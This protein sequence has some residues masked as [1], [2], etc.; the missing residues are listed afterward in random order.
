[1][2]ID[3]ALVSCD[4]TDMRIRGRNVLALLCGTTVAGF[5]WLA[6]CAREGA[7]GARSVPPPAQT[8]PSTIASLPVPAAATTPAATVEPKPTPPEPEPVLGADHR[9]AAPCEAD[10]DCGWDDPCVPARCLAAV[11][12]DV[13]MKCAE[14]RPPPGAC[15]CMSG[16]CT[17]KPKPPPKASGP[18]ENRGCV[19]DRAGGQCIADT[20]GVKVNFRTNSGVDVGPSC[21]CLS[22][23]KGCDFTWYEP[24]PC[25]TVRDCWV[26]SLPRPHPVKRPGHLRGR[27]FKPC[28]DGEV[29]PQCSQAGHCVLGSHWSC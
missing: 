18:C 10:A 26:E 28:S 24:V 22:P 25:K 14:S 11:T 29:S 2:V 3:G 20:R 13:D 19:V 17:L 1:M 27:D 4:L 23:A 16:R 6:G 7:S 21:D 8:V 9:S 15:M 5:C 12:T